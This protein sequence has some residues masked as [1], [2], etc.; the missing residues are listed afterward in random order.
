MIPLAKKSAQK[1]LTLIEM[2]IAMT[3]SL[4]LMAGATSMFL[5]SKRTF[6]VQEESARIQE[7]MRYVV[8]RMIKDI[9]PAGFQGCAPS[10]QKGIS[11]I[12]STVVATHPFSDFSAAITG[13]EGG[14]N[15]PDKL[16]VRFALPELS[17]PI[18]AP[19]TASDRAVHIDGSSKIYK[20]N[21][22]TGDIIAV[23]DCSLLAVFMITNAGADGRLAH[24]AGA[25]TNSTAGTT[26]YFGGEPYSSATVMKMDAVTYELDKKTDT[27][28]T[29]TTDD[30][31]TISSLYATRLGG[32]RQEILSGVEDFQ[33]SYGIDNTATPD[34]TSDRYIDWTTV[35]KE[36]LEHRIASL[37][38]TLGI[39]AGNPI[40][41]TDGIN[42]D[43]A[44]KIK[45]VVKLRNRL[46]NL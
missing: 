25:A 19:M 45:F 34:G 22:S 24:T 36:N 29:K 10:T 30:D 43:F 4:L 21:Y 8:T 27:K 12:Q 5:S 31:T 20:D 6:K 46:T 17:L 11:Q 18:I 7:N 14:K 38:I 37:R 3:L 35:L 33:V 23:S 41:G 15:K 40:Q 13:E 39:N 9:S 42:H 2:M 32:N 44:Q 16:T 1:G 28:K 26:H